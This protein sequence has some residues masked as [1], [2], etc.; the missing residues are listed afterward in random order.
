MKKTFL[1]VM[2]SF[3]IAGCCS[4]K[5]CEDSCVKDSGTTFAKDALQKYVDSKEIPGAICVYYD[6]GVQETACGSGSRIRMVCRH[7]SRRR[8][9]SR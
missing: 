5:Q 8:M 2:L 3:L 9:F 1:Y 6:N 4:V 7:L